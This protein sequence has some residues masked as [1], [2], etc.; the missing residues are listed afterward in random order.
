MCEETSSKYKC[1][2][3]STVSRESAPNA[4]NFDSPLTTVSGAR[5]SWFLTIS[6]TL[7]SVSGLACLKK[8]CS[9]FMAVFSFR[10]RIKKSVFSLKLRK[11]HV[12]WMRCACTNYL[13]ISNYILSASSNKRWNWQSIRIEQWT[14]GA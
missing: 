11:L 8:L 14:N 10:L 1:R 12:W 4:T 5:A 6:Q 3:W 7:F 9:S 13:P 2:H